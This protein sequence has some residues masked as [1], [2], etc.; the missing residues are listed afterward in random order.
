MR[1]APKE[2][3]FKAD[4]CCYTALNVPET[5]LKDIV[6]NAKKF[7]PPTVSAPGQEKSMGEVEKSLGA[8]RVVMG[9]HK[10]S[11]TGSHS[12][13]GVFQGGAPYV[14]LV[15]PASPSSTVSVV[16][17]DPV[18]LPQPKAVDA[19]TGKETG[20]RDP[21]TFVSL[22]DGLLCSKDSVTGKSKPYG[23]FY[24]PAGRFVRTTSVNGHTVVVKIHGLP[25]SARVEDINS[26]NFVAFCG[27][28]FLNCSLSWIF[29]SL[30]FL[31]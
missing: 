2:N 12:C 31:P 25:Q 7:F 20:S 1:L 8:W 17:S 11:P 10:G 30:S 28:V 21:H 5:I 16:V 24:I 13:Y 19:S 22:E 9:M 15:L 26:F 27:G 23:A 6:D 4:G 18:K 14:L 29:R 3:A